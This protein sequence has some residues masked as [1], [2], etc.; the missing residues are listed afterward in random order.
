MVGADGLF[1][2]EG[3]KGA[4]RTN[5]KKYRNNGEKN[6]RGSER[7][8]NDL[9]NSENS[10]RTNEGFEDDCLELLKALA[11]LTSRES[12]LKFQFYQLLEEAKIE[13]IRLSGI[14]SLYEMVCKNDNDIQVFRLKLKELF[15]KYVRSLS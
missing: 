12:A 6:S 5:F 1:K 8:A 2:G 11:Q 9:S 13:T 7:S 14:I 3:D 10:F 15:S 4:Y